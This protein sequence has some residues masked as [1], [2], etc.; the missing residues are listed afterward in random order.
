[1]DL[2][3]PSPQR[4]R[5]AAKLSGLPVELV[6]PV[7][8]D[9]PL[10]RVLELVFTSPSP[11]G[12]VRPVEECP[13]WRD[14]FI[15][16]FVELGRT[17]TS[18]NRLAWLWFSE[19]WMR[20]MDG[21][22][23][24]RLL[25]LSPRGLRDI[26]G[27]NIRRVLD[28]TF[29]QA[30]RDLLGCPTVRVYKGPGTPV[31]QALCLFLPVDLLVGLARSDKLL[32]DPDHFARQSDD[33]RDY[34]ANPPDEVTLRDVYLDAVT[35][36][37]WTVNEAH[38]FLPYL[39]RARRLLAQAYSAQLHSLAVA[40]ERF[41]AELKTPLAPE[42][43]RPNTRHIADRLH[44]DA[45]RVLV[46]RLAKPRCVRTGQPVRRHF[47]YRFRFLVTAL[48][49]YNW[50]LRL[51]LVVVERHPLSTDAG[52]YPPAV[53]P[54]VR[55]ALG[56]MDVIHQHGGQ[57]IS[58]RR[59]RYSVVSGTPPLAQ[60]NTFWKSRSALPKPAAEVEWLESFASAVHWM[61]AEFPDLVALVKDP[62]ASPTGGPSGDWSGPTA[63]EAADYRLMIAQEPARDIAARLRSDSIACESPDGSSPPPSLLALYMP[64][65]SARARAIARHLVPSRKVGVEAQ[66]L[67][68]SDLIAKIKHK[69]QTTAGAGGKFP[70]G[71]ECVG[72][73]GGR[74][75]GGGLGSSELEAAAKALR[76]FQQD[77][78]FDIDPETLRKLLGAIHL[79]ESNL[80]T[81][82]VAP[83]KTPSQPSSSRSRLCYI[84]QMQLTQPHSIFAAMCVPCGDFN[85]AG[86]DV[87]QPH[88]L[89]LYGM[90]ALVTGGRVNLGY[91]TARRLLRCGA[92]VIVSTRYPHDALRRFRLE[93]G[94]GEWMRR[95]RI[96]GADFR[97]ARDAFALVEQVRALVA[98]FGGTLDILINNAA[99]TLTDSIGQEEDA[100]SR[101]RQLRLTHEPSPALP[102]QSY[103]PRVRG[104]GR[105]AIEGPPPPAKA[106]PPTEPRSSKAPWWNRRSLSRS[107]RPSGG[108]SK[109]AASPE[110]PRPSAGPSKAVAAPEPQGSSWVQSLSQIPYDDV[111]S[112]HS[113]N[114]FVPLI[115]V[116][117]LSPLMSRKVAGERAAKGYIVNVS[118][119]EGIF[120]RRPG[121]PAKQGKHVHTNMSKAGLNMITETEASTLWRERRVAM[122]T[123]DPGYMSAA[124][125]LEDSHGG[126]RPL[127]WE[128]GVG[129]VLWP[130]AV[131]QS[132]TTPV[133]GRFLKHYGASRVEPG[134]GR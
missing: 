26:F 114:T 90:T 126:A 83:G 110:P 78:S 120:E 34:L 16:D 40:Y 5:V 15:G 101:E 22:S 42:T 79:A 35:A 57:D 21:L 104:E 127:G 64:S 13:A 6:W 29:L 24:S 115:L 37:V 47:G 109:P 63:A 67:V 106:L 116:R 121:H 123:V 41:P 25:R 134:L 77:P 60:F 68:Y 96:V 1:M 62:Q 14:F 133:Y 74:G 12:L 89:H 112:A 33:Y 3:P 27:T 97:A 71:N 45:A 32:Q 20:T 100:I 82:Q 85:L 28:D 18:L 84:C 8:E 50:C 54:D 70:Q 61:T 30:F 103:D 66:Q 53:L 113:V 38:R 129:R 128:D 99:Q 2:P 46:G 19:P 80:A 44:E 86:N 95:L 56:G 72:E 131:G 108:P 49:P 65:W 98:E 69:L 36:H 91:H 119:R 7:V 55:V 105:G 87:S 48:V 11:G 43:P 88:K 124:P 52:R 94:S 31:T 102:A 10:H 17:W 39:A 75:D 125:E 130:V 132:G 9:L 117:E 59:P 92:N 58:A 107:P 76:F 51:F 122:N 4:S 73:Q 23:L 118:S 111:I 81:S 93:M